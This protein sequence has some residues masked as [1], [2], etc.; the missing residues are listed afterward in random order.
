V[1]GFAVCVRSDMSVC[2][3]LIRCFSRCKLEHYHDRCSVLCDIGRPYLVTGNEDKV[4]C[5]T[6]DVV[7]R[8]E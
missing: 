4:V 8:R 2:G 6:K 5:G 3:R 7:G 1:T